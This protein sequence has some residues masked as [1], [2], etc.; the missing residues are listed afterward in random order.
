M[1]KQ[2]PVFYFNN[3]RP[4]V[5]PSYFPQAELIM[6][7]RIFI[8]YGLSA[9]MDL[10]CTSSVLAQSLTAPMMSHP[11]ICAHRGWTSPSGTENSLAEMR[12]THKAG[13]FMMEIDLA[14]D[15]TGQIVLL[16][17]LDVDRTT[18]G[19][20]PLAELNQKAV[21][22]LRL[23][24]SSGPTGEHIPAYSD[25]LDWAARRPD[26]LLMLDIK[27]VPPTDAL[28]PVRHQSLSGRVVV[29]TFHEKQAREAFE[30]DP[31]ALVSVLVTKP[32]DL[33]TYRKISGTRR[34]AAYV[35]QNSDPALFR[36]AYEAGAVVITDLLGPTAIVDAV[37]PDEGA[38]RA[39]ALPIDILV[40]NTPLQLQSALRKRL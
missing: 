33:A 36:A 3:R 28:K 15:K 23:R 5:F 24:N 40:T 20:G 27:D 22:K 21:Q 4:T 11:L 12:R 39:K 2:K 25:V 9:L 38:Q 17:D 6:K 31:N 7:R 8:V 13:P 18:T 29:L 35:P 32:D 16:H 10:S 37:S 26:V 19:H 1:S 30:A 34:F 14:K